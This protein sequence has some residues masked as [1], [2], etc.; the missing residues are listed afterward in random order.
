MTSSSGTTSGAIAKRREETH[1]ILCVEDASDC[2]KLVGFAL[3]DY[4]IEV[5]SSLAEARASLRAQQFSLVLLDIELPDGTGLEL[6]PEI[7][8]QSQELPV[9]MVTAK[10]DLGHKASAFTFGADDYIH[11]PFDPVEMR[12]RVEARLRRRDRRLSLADRFEIGDLTCSLSEQ[13]LYRHEPQGTRVIALTGL[14]F[15]LFLLFARGIGQVYA[16]SMIVERVW[17]PGINITDRTID[18]HVAHLRK[19][20]GDCKVRIETVFGSGYRAT[21]TDRDPSARH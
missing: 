12:L 17:G 13:R 21:L 3:R 11:K 14:E 5:A 2:Q 20:L 19:K 10:G 18:T 4:S 6:L 16:R 7:S 1:R 15:K 9:I 8:R